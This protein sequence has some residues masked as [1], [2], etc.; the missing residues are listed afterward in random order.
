MG[1]RLGVIVV[2]VV[3]LVAVAAAQAPVPVVMWHGMGDNC[4]NPFSMGRIQ[5]LIEKSIGSGVYVKSIMIGS[6]PEEDTINGFLMNVDDQIIDACKQITADPK[7]ASGFHAIGF[8]QGGQ[9]VI[10]IVQSVYYLVFL[11]LF[12]DSG[13]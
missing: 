4:C 12:H 9:S 6:N 8:S 2:F 1:R 3:S 13:F 5:S 7:L 10:Y 11:T